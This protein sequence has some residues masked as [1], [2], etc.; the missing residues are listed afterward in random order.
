MLSRKTYLSLFSLRNLYKYSQMNYAEVI[1]ILSIIKHHRLRAKKTLYKYKE[2]NLLAQEFATELNAMFK[3]HNS[4]LKISP[5]VHLV[6]TLS[7]AK[8][9]DI[10]RVWPDMKDSNTSKVYCLVS[11]GVSAGM[12]TF[13]HEQTMSLIN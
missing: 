10:N 12:V 13:K 4:D 1:I 9:G 2:N 5:K 11:E 7:Y 3:E 6:K 8:F